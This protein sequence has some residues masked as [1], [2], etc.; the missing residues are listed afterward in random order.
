MNTYF[1]KDLRIANKHMKKCSLSSVI[2]GLLKNNMKYYLVSTRLANN[3][4]I[5][6]INY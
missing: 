6:K 1:T 5:D 3:K 4:N 2:R